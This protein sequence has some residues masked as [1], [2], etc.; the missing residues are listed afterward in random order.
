MCIL[1]PRK[2]QLQHL[3]VRKCFFIKA[4]S[5]AVVFF[6][7]PRFIYFSQNICILSRDPVPL[8]FFIFSNTHFS[9]LVP[10]T[11]QNGSDVVVDGLVFATTKKEKKL[12]ARTTFIV[13]AI[14]RI[15]WP[16]C[17]FFSKEVFLYK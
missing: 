2:W 4:I 1:T 7:R 6:F 10:E 13:A 17:D 11:L 8:V 5:H 15:R 3:S 16:C 9:H 14:N 12:K